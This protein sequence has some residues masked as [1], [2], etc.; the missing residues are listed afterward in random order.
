M[1]DREYKG[2][3]GRV[4]VRD[5]VEFVEHVLTGWANSESGQLEQLRDEIFNLRRETANMLL[6]IDREK[7]IKYCEEY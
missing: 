5:D 1:A 3:N 6:A 2:W 4:H 7:V